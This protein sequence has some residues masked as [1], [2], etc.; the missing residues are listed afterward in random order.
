MQLNAIGCAIACRQGAGVH[1][2]HMDVCLMR[3]NKCVYLGRRD[4]C[5]AAG[6]NGCCVA[7]GHSVAVSNRRDR[8]PGGLE[9]DRPRSRGC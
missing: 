4:Q 2:A 3:I 8:L 1:L 6:G 9:C 7:R 5:G